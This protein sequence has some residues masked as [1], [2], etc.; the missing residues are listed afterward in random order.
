MGTELPAGWRWARI[1]SFLTESRLA[2]SDG[3]EA[4][5]LTVK[6]Y[7]LGVIAKEEK[8]LGSRNTRYFK[9]R[10]GQFIYS[11]LDFLNGAFGLIP[12]EL[13]GRESTADLPAFDVHPSVD[14]QWFLSYV[15]RPVFYERQA[16]GA[17][18]S[19]KARRV[20]PKEF[21]GLEVAAPPLPEQKKIAAILGAVDA[22]I[23]ATQAVIDQTRRV[24]AGL[25]QTLLTRGIGHTR[26]KKTAIGEIPESWRVLTV[27]DVAEGGALGVVGG[28][29]GSRL[30]SSDYRPSGVPV[31]RGSNMTFA[32]GT[33]NA[34]PTA[35]VFVSED[36]AMELNGNQAARGD[37]IVTQRGT[38]GQVALIPT[39][40]PFERF[41]VSQSQMR[42]RANPDLVAGT[43][44]FE[45]LRSPNA[46]AWVDAQTVGTGVPH[47]NLGML[48]E[49]PIPVPP[50]GEQTALVA[51]L[52]AFSAVEERA[53]GEAAHLSEVKAG[54]LQDL[55]T[56]KVRV[57]P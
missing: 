33:F 14:P 3:R 54:L 49:M 1:G 23:Q 15:S 10:A 25:L 31:I 36:K 12:E 21:L 2:G 57:T 22:A 19:R 42:V 8:T 41:V 29:F 56:G 50:L 38:V 9:R 40:C 32:T 4:S 17:I 53:A 20:N 7:G 30:T 5:K 55:L 27:A 48:R 35:F 47:I 11:K 24:K 13:D 39:N 46:T 16:G 45:Y 6:L 34:E 52:A 37:V 51:R 18:G 26:F 28:P 44:L 43:F